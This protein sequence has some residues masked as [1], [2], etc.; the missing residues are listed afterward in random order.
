MLE[1]IF[2]LSFLF[3]LPL[4]CVKLVIKTNQNMYIKTHMCISV[5]MYVDYRYCTGELILYKENSYKA[6]NRTRP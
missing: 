6:A 2:H 5:C 1:E 3:L 4:D